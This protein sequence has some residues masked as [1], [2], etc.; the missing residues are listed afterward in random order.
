M[1]SRSCPCV[2]NALLREALFHQRCCHVL[3]PFSYTFVQ[4]CMCCAETA[5]ELFMLEAGFSH[6]NHGSYGATLKASQ[7][8]ADVWRSALESGPSQFMEVR[9]TYETHPLFCTYPNLTGNTKTACGFLFVTVNLAQLRVNEHK[10]SQN[11]VLQCQSKACFRLT[12]FPRPAISNCKPPLRASMVRA[13]SSC[14]S[15][16]SS[17]Q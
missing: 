13:G 3:F 17:S 10:H 8:A 14:A 9:P 5:Q 11:Y 15:F 4:S 2:Y 7:A 6:L 12:M 1:F 16:G